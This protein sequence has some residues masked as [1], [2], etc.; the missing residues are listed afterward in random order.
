M[1]LLAKTF[2]PILKKH[3]FLTTLI[4][5]TEY[6]KL[7]FSRRFLSQHVSMTNNQLKVEATDKIH[8]LKLKEIHLKSLSLETSSKT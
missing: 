3:L 5:L 4:F 2:F 6:F 1:V 8:K 7:D